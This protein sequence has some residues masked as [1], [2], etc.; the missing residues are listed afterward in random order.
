MNK[1]SLRL[2]TQ[3]P[4]QRI[5]RALHVMG[6]VVTDLSLPMPVRKAVWNG[7]AALHAC[8]SPETVR[9]MEQDMGIGPGGDAA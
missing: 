9:K 5:E 1:P 6:E 4:E 2:V 3:T 8:R 7:Y